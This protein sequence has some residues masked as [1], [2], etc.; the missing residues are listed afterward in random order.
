VAVK[1]IFVGNLDFGVTEESLR[2]L[3]LNGMEV[4]KVSM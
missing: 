3:S 2:S 4:W 1:K